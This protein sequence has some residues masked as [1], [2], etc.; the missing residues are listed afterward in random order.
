MASRPTL[1]MPRAASSL[2]PGWCEDVNP[3]CPALE[4]LLPGEVSVTPP[5]HLPGNAD[6]TAVVGPRDPIF[7]NYTG[8]S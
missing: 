5:K 8:L 3:G 2:A 1:V 6:S 4:P 7:K